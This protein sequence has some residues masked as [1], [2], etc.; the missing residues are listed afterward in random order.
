MAR[1]DSLA[2]EALARV[3]DAGA[4]FAYLQ[5]TDILGSVKGVTIP[6]SRLERA[7]DEGVWFDGSSVEGWARVAES[8][9]FLRPDPATLALFAWE[10]PP[11][12][13]F[14]CDLGLPSGEPFPGDSRQ[15]LKRVLAE[16]GEAGFDY[17]V[18]AEFEFFLFLDGQSTTQG[19][20]RGLEPSDAE[21][22]YSMPTERT[23][24]LCHEVART[25][26]QCGFAVAAT[27][28]EVSPGQ[29]EIDLAEHDALRAADAI[30]TLKIAL[31]AY[32]QREKLLATFMPKPLAGLSGSGLHLQQALFD[33][34]SGRNAFFAADATYHLS[35]TGR[36]FVAGQ[37]AHA[38][39]M[40]ALMAP[41]VNSY[42]RLTGGGEA[43]ASID[44]ARINRGALIRVPELGLDGQRM[45]VELRS[46]DPSCN[47][48]LALAAALKAGLEGIA[49]GTPL[50]EPVEERFAD[51]TAEAE[52]G[53]DPLPRT[54][55]EA[56]EELEWDPLVRAALG[57]SIYE[58]FLAAK[59]QEWAAYRNHISLWEIESY[60]QRA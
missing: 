38:R 4:D 45:F 21:S 2:S 28:H 26:E 23:L 40:C 19:L 52:Q 37:L 6:A 12:V 59:E 10:D 36:A 25:L 55:G 5:F 35:D 34:G 33:R 42:K 51:E 53:A 31:R 41:L 49:G 29:H 7:F 60:L 48:Y 43:P 24:R 44:W 32:G 9:L 47:P 57:Q 3:R 13:R 58:R 30:A 20:A 8:D 46:P 11:A 22:Y 54:L 18:A 56:I 1:T 14:I 27:H 16:A 39:G 17:R 15:A 50:A